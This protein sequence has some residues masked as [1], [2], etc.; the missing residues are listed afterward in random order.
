MKRKREWTLSAS[1]TI[2]AA[3]L[4]PLFLFA[5]MKGLL[6]GI[7]CYEEMSHAASAEKQLEAV[8]P[9]EWIWENRLWDQIKEE[10]GQRGNTVSEKSEK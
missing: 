1:Y 2:E 10:L 6:L 7:T 5:L 9:T 3:L 4:M 8:H